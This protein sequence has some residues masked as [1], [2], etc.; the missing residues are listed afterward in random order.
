[1]DS[2]PFGTSPHDL[3][4]SYSEQYTE[5]LANHLSL[6]SSGVSVVIMYSTQGMAYRAIGGYHVPLDGGGAEL[7]TLKDQVDRLV[8]GREKPTSP[9]PAFGM[10]RRFLRAGI[11]GRSFQILLDVH[12]PIP[13]P[14]QP[15][16][17]AIHRLM[18]KVAHS[19]VLAVAARAELAPAKVSV[20]DD[21]KV[22]IE[23]QNVG[24]RPVLLV[25]PATFGRGPSTLRINFWRPTGDAD[26]PHDYEWTLDLTGR[27]LLV[28]EHETL[29]SRGPAIPLEPH[30][31]LRTWTTVELPRCKP[32]AYHAELIYVASPPSHPAETEQRVFG[33]LHADLVPMTVERRKK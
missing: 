12:D 24:S 19:P 17:D 3:S 21:L 8:R 4:V 30:A 29:A 10:H 33:E 5:L 26:E 23:F 16:V 32:A 11:D 6:V 15:T 28:A 27:E 22:S 7:A 20:G 13:A 1:M 2:A 14:V 31:K 25:N 18:E 9:P